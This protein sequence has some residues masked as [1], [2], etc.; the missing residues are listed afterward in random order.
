MDQSGHGPLWGPIPGNW[1]YR[2]PVLGLTSI[3]QKHIFGIKV[4][5][6]LCWVFGSYS[7]DTVS[8]KIGSSV[9]WK[10]SAPESRLKYCEYSHRHNYNSRS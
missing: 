9:P 4:D 1:I 8:V 5:A 3:W 10:Y 6:H 7:V 2:I